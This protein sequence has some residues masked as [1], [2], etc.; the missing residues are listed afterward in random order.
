M[1]LLCFGY[2]NG[3][4]GRELDYHVA[5]WDSRAGINHEWFGRLKTRSLVFSTKK[6]TL[7][8]DGKNFCSPGGHS[9]R[10]KAEELLIKAASDSVVNWPSKR[11]I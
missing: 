11:Y 10:R 9:H 2:D 6:A 3:T 7:E 1:T 8:C 5:V 4:F